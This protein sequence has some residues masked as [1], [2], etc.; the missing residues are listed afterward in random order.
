MD[1]TLILAVVVSALLGLG[2]GMQ[3][4]FTKDI[5]EVSFLGMLALGWIVFEALSVLLA[6]GTKTFSINFFGYVFLDYLFFAALVYIF[7]LTNR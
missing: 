3:N 2:A 5:P 6:I 7:R 4:R 1:K